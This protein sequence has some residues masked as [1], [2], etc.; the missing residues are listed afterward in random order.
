MGLR[1]SLLPRIGSVHSC[2]LASYRAPFELSADWLAAFDTL[3]FFPLQEF[4]SGSGQ[5]TVAGHWTH[6]F[7]DLRES[8]V[9]LDD[10]IKATSS[11]KTICSR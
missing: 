5:L 8:Q 9:R 6:R 3:M 11:D 2:N 10:D 4:I 1:G 7:Q